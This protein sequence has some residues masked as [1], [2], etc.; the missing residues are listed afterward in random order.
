MVVTMILLQLRECRRQRPK[1]ALKNTWVLATSLLVL[2]TSSG[3][4]LLLGNIKPV[5]E[6]SETYGVADLSK[7]NPAEWTRLDPSATD[8]NT[9]DAQAPDS[10]SSE[11]SDVVYQSKKTAATISINSACRTGDE[12]ETDLRKISDLLFLGIS[13]VTLRDEKPLQLQGTPALQTT[14]I[15]NLNHERVQ[16]RT[17]VLKRSDCVY[18]VIYLAPPQS[19]SKNEKDFAHF[20]DSLRLK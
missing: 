17:V 9:P 15:G 4:G 14:L 16:I 12:A 1:T 19:F 18:D 20:V 8:K 11:I 10:R 13:D 6:K 3:C 5:D 2:V 7:E